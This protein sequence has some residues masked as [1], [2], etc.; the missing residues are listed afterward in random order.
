MGAARL[1]IRN[2]FL[3]EKGNPDKIIFEKKTLV[4]S[5]KVEM[6][7]NDFLIGLGKL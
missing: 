7:R 3:E 6:I 5:P 2:L 4:F 1:K